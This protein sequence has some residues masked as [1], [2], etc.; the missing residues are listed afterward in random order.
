MAYKQVI[1][2][3]QGQHSQASHGKGGG[4]GSD[5]QGKIKQ[6]V[7]QEVIIKVGQSNVDR[8]G[9]LTT[10]GSDGFKILGRPTTYTFDQVENVTGNTIRIK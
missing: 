5:I 1:K 3:L 8:K 7:N 4:G 2:H 6:L 9:T 10:R